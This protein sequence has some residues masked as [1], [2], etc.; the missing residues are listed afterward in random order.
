[1]MIDLNTKIKD[2]KT[3]E[4]GFAEVELTDEIVTEIRK[5]IKEF[6]ACEYGDGIQSIDIKS[7]TISTEGRWAEIYA[8]LETCRTVTS[9]GFRGD[10]WNPPEDHV[11]YYDNKEGIE[12]NTDDINDE[13]TINE[14]M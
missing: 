10:Y 4:D 6:D 2:L 9:P 5:M 11:S 8:D 13:M 1:M 7:F 3:D 14:L 12:F